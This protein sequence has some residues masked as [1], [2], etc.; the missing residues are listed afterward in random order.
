MKSISKPDKEQIAISGGVKKSQDSFAI[1]ADWS[2]LNH[3]IYSIL[4]NLAIIIDS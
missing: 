2:K 1:I 3:K 4:K